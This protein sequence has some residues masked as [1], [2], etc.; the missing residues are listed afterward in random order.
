MVRALFAVFVLLALL[1]DARIFL[2]V[3]NRYVFGDHK[4]EHS[5]WKWM[6]FVVPPLLLALTALIWPLGQWIQWVLTSSFV[7]R[8]TPSRM[9]DALWSIA[10]AKIGAA[11]LII[12][13]SVGTLWIVERLRAHLAPAEQLSGIREYPAEVT[14]LRP[15]HVPFAWLRRLGAHNDL[16]DIEVT[17]HDLFIDDLPEAFDGYRIAFLTDTH[18]ASFVRRDF[19]RE[20]IA[21][22][23][24][25]NPDSVFLGGDF[26]TWKRHIPLAAEVL[27]PDLHPPDGLYAVLGNHDIWA[28]AEEVTQAFAAHGVEFI[29]NRSVR[30]RRDGAEIALLGIDEIYRG[31]PDVTA[32][33]AGVD[34]S[35][36]CLGISHHPDVI[37]LLDGRR[38]DLLVCGH[39]HGGQIRFPFFGP[40]VV[41]SAHEWELASGFHRIR[42]VLMYVSRGIGAIPPVRI[43]CRPEVA[44]FVLRRGLRA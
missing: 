37:D 23:N 15:Q 41:P 21:R 7:E 39:T 34:E 20:C 18:V 27:L 38:L 2:Y 32:A 40:V 8:I 30:L 6:M 25:F 43:L 1:G 36:P 33:F 19:Y 3:M 9:E 12:A 4:E 35:K 42:N 22:V 29:Q 10:F 17:R 13:A 5:P 26:V 31:K 44:T 16:Y 24:A 28:G 11:W 14:R